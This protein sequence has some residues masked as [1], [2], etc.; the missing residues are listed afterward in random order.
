LA[1]TSPT[2]YGPAQF[3][4]AY[5]LPTTASKAQT[6]AIVDAYDDPTIESD[7]AAYSATYGLP[8]CTTGNGCFRKV[9][10]SGQDSYP[11]T[12]G[13]WALE[14][15]LDVETAHAICQNCKIL[16]VE[17]TTNSFSNLTAAVEMAA[18]LGATEISNSYGGP[19]FS[20]EVSGTYADP[21]NHPGIAI[22]VSAGDS[23]YGAE[24]PASSPYVVAVGGTTLALGA[25]NSYGGETAWSGSG[26]GCSAYVSAQSWQTSDAN[27]SLTGCGT[28]RGI[29]DVAA[30]AN[31]NTGASVYDTTKDQ[32]QAGWFQVGG[33]SLSAPMIA[34]VYALAGGGGVDYPAAD[35]YGHQTDSPAS[36]HDVT[37]G[38]NGSC[39]GTTMC[40]GATGY[41]GPTGVGTPKGIAAF[42]A[43]GVDTTP[44]QTTI[45]FAPSSPTNDSTPTFSF[46]SS[47]AGSTFGCS[48]DGAAFVGCT[49][50]YT[51]AALGDGAH[52]FEV[53]ATDSSGNTDASPV[54]IS[55][56]VD[57]QAPSIGLASP[58]DAS[59]I[60]TATPALSGTAGTASG[61]SSTVTVKVYAGT[62]TGGTLLQTRSATR[63]PSTGA[64]SVNAT[65]L[66]SGTYT[67]Q[68]SQGDSAGN[69]GLSAAHTFT[70]DITA[71]P[72]IPPPDPTPPDIA[73]AQTTNDSQAIPTLQVV[74]PTAVF[75]FE[76]VG[77]DERGNSVTLTVDV[78]GPGTLVLFGRKVQKVR[79]K[80]MG[81]DP[82]TLTVRPKKRLESRPRGL[83]KAKVNVSY[84]PLG[85]APATKT[86]WVTFRS[87][88]RPPR[89]RASAPPLPK[90]G[91]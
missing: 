25:S 37:S 29:A 5:E 38:S 44:P 85:G 65:T 75:S 33:T 15:S 88:R 89:G 21:Y 63:D 23:G 31:P 47:E 42:A 79:K 4:G 60:S 71:L 56:T 41:D 52:K 74:P 55:L 59:F 86:T 45:T 73:P 43:G 84:T 66:G 22:T 70:V 2:G 64:Y 3:H 36:L 67:A 53:R 69:T 48:V 16:L 49:S 34:A 50:P 78:P 26:S 11:K 18:G 24:Y 72:D 6:V 61:D 35:P 14:I 10:Q 83:G 57:T 1:T 40:T 12:D 32:G 7:L 87:G 90:R 19:E 62:G 13:G 30:D 76:K 27:W 81:A 80:A 68:A 28:K 77:H 20:S 58:A 91:L 17:A 46:S 54:S 8:A 39:G 9:N 51:T 82:I